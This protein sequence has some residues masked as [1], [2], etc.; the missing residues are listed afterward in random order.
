MTTYKIV[1]KPSVKK[2]IRPIPEKVI[3]K[4]FNKIDELR[5]NPYPKSSVKI[6]ASKR[7]YRLRVSDYPIIYEV[8]NQSKLIIIHYIRHRRDAYKSL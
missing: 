8:D 3:A 7:Q 6:S 5:T 4:I 1:V 2:D